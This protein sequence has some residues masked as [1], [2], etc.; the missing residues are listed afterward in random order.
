[1]GSR[2]NFVS[3]AP[4]MVTQNDSALSLKALGES[5]A[6]FVCATDTATQK[7][8]VKVVLTIPTETPT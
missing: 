8:K 3:N 7:D 6:G 1:M 4:A 5:E 2:R